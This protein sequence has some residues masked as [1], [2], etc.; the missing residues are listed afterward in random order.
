[1]PGSQ[2]IVKVSGVVLAAAIAVTIVIAA[3]CGTTEL[4]NLWKDPSYSAPPL[5]KL[6]VI[7]FRKNQINRR[8]WEDA[9][10]GTIAKENTTAVV[11]PSYQLFPN[12]VPLPDSVK[13]KVKD[14][15]FDGVLIVSKVERD[16]LTNQV[17]GYTTS[18]PVTEYSRKWKSYQTRYETVYHPGYTDTSMTVRVRTDLLLTQG[19][20]D[21]GR[22]IWS[23]TSESVDPASHDEFRT[24]VANS[25]AKA[26]T[27]AR[28][29][30]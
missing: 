2:V 7:A 14:Q 13:E 26:L 23:A 27:K 3:G 24:S 6:M 17:P 18:E 16:T 1:M 4:T 29:I 30:K 20:G 28:L 11:V 12:E 21:E 19:E 9:V 15:G 25:V 22:L 8:M 5:K 10:V